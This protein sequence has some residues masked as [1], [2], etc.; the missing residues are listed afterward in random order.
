VQ[1]RSGDDNGCRRR[2]DQAFGLA[3]QSRATFSR[4]CAAH[5]VG[6]WDA[7]SSVGWFADPP[8]LPYTASNPDIAIG[9][10]AVAI[11]ERRA[12]FCTHLW[13]PSVKP[14]MAGPWDLKQVW[15]EAGGVSA[16]AVLGRGP[17]DMARQSF[18]GAHLASAQQ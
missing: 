15:L 17:Q 18:P 16:G 1:G 5:F 6:V 3:R 10:R 4:P 2:I 11:D 9:R 12:F 13:K 7:V 8:S 14:A